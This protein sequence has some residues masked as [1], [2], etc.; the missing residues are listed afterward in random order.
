HIQVHALVRLRGVA[1][2]VAGVE[3]DAVDR[4]RT[5]AQAVGVGV[6]EDV[7]AMEALDH[8]TLAACVAGEAGVAGGAVPGRDDSSS[9]GEAGRTCGLADHPPP[10][11]PRRRPGRRRGGEGG[12]SGRVFVRLEEGEAGF[13]LLL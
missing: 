5:L 1:P 3:A 6:W 2:E 8:T 11:L 12:F 4:L 10:A 7:D 9:G 13:H